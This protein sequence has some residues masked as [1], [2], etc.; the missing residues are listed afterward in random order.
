MLQALQLWPPF[1]HKSR[2]KIYRTLKTKNNNTHRTTLVSL[3]DRT[4]YSLPISYVFPKYVNHRTTYVFVSGPY[5]V[6]F[7]NYFRFF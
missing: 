3:A 7:A 1:L 5:L 6:Q 4:Q 2:Q